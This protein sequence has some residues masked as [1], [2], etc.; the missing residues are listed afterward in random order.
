MEGIVLLTIDSLV[1]KYPGP[2]EWCEEIHQEVCEAVKP[3]R[4][5]RGRLPSANA[6]IF[7]K[8]HTTGESLHLVCTEPTVQALPVAIQ[9]NHE[10]LKRETAIKAPQR[11]LREDFPPSCL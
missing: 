8:M 10:A 3:A 7:L 4:R 2:Y 9:S 6:E 5:L 11:T 1:A